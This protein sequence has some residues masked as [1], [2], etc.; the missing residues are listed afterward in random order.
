MQEVRL[1]FLNSV[2]YMYIFSL[3]KPAVCSSSSMLPTLP[4]R[5]ALS[6]NSDERYDVKRNESRCRAGCAAPKVELPSRTVEIC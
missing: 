6:E 3:V 4:A 5:S 2:E 1:R